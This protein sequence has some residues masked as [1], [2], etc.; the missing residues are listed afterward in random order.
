MSRKKMT[1]VVR[2]LGAVVFS[3]LSMTTFGLGTWQF[4]R[5]YEKSDTIAARKE[6]LY[7]L[8]RSVSSLFE[9]PVKEVLKDT[10]LWTERRKQAERDHRDGLFQR[11]RC[12]GKY[13]DGV[14]LLGP[15]A[16]PKLSAAY[17]DR[18]PGAEKNGFYI[19]SPFRCKDG[20]QI[21]V[22]RGWV[23]TSQMKSTTAT[24]WEAAKD[25]QRSSV[26]A[27]TGVTRRGEE[28]GRFSPDPEL[29]KGRHFW[30][31]MKAIAEG[32]GVKEEKMK[33]IFLDVVPEGEEC[34]ESAGGGESSWWWWWL[35]GKNEG[36]K[37]DKQMDAFR[38]SGG[39]IPVAKPLDAHMD[40]Y[41]TRGTHA[42]YSAT[43]YS[44][45][46]CLFALTWLKFRR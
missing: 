16:P 26:K 33:A 43:W 23:P 37:K 45:S 25:P 12:E 35:S 21:V 30:L 4:K 7:S 42:G 34:L 22:C 1:P 46:V 11:F 6:L 5:Y 29:D 28:R 27:V 3:G 24:L 40:F 9:E 18:R 14:A 44:L 2:R 13:E 15:R 8:P 31:D 41:V 19:Y 32:F 10:T 17:E 20:R 38:K 36:E 39:F